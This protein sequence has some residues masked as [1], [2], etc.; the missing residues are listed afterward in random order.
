MYIAA[1]W[2][3]TLAA[4]TSGR[5]PEEHVAAA[6]T[7]SS[8]A[9]SQAANQDEPRSTVLMQFNVKQ[10]KFIEEK[11]QQAAE[12]QREAAEVQ[13]E[14]VEAYRPKLL[15]S[16]DPADHPK[17]KAGSALSKIL[18][19]ARENSRKSG[20]AVDYFLDVD[21]QHDANNPLDDVKPI[22]VSGH[23][24]RYRSYTYDRRTPT[25]GRGPVMLSVCRTR[26][27]ERATSVAIAIA[28][29]G[30]PCVFGVDPLDEGNHC[31]LD[32]EYGTFGWCYT[33]KDK[34][35]WGICSNSCPLSGPAHVLERR[36][37]EMESLM[38]ELLVKVKHK[39]DC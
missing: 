25:G 19:R 18:Q 8:C 10:Q 1:A 23:S 2:L 20:E 3:A 12:V 36:I 16:A 7:S 35:A 21:Y 39:K 9:A 37:D 38:T 6:S 27:D 15:L 26:L 32:P 33:A 30:T 24:D 17:P 13:R 4:A 11:T 34:S 31:I 29:P 5:M 22:P 14:A 28:A